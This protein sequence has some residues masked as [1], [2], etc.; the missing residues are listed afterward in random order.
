MLNSNQLH[1]LA[2]NLWA[3]MGLAAVAAIALV[4]LAAHY[5]W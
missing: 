5:I 2:D 4:A 3:Q 1:N